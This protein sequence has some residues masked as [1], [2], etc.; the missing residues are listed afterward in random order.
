VPPEVTAVLTTHVRPRHVFDALA[1]LRAE[2][3]E[4]VEIIVVDDGGEFPA[5]AVPGP[6]VRIIRGGSLGIGRARNLGLAAAQGE[7]IIFLD[8]DDVALPHRISSLV[9]A[10]RRGGASL[11]FGMTRRVALGR[12]ITLDA[13]PTHLR[14]HGPAGFCDVLTCNPHVNA[15]L[16]RTEALRAVGG[17]DVEASHFDDWS[18]WLR[19]ADRETTLWSIGDIVAEWRV[20]AM[21]LSAQVLTIR[22]MKS[23]LLALFERLQPCLSRENARAVAMARRIVMLNEITTYD[24]YVSAMA[25]AREALHSAGRCFG[26]PLEW[27]QRAAAPANR[28]RPVLNA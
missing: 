12:A 19:V 20:H 13:V 11:C 2:T 7:F 27:H 5:A 8:D 16:V 6:P 21:G 9:R 4:D 18:A 23:R 3:H 10:A 15:V 14:L 24:D 25:G 17:F 1:S 26:R 22:A 28:K